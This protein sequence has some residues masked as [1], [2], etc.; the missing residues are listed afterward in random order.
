[1][2]TWTSDELGKIGGTDEL[3]IASRR[4]D[5]TLNSPRIIWVFRLDD[6]LYVR[7]VNARGSAWFRGTQ[8]RHEGHIQAGGVSKNVTFTDPGRRSRRPDRRCL[9]GQVPPTCGEH[10]RPHHQPASAGGDHQTRAGHLGARRRVSVDSLP[11]QPTVKA[12]GGDVHR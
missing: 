8:V 9:P 11:K 10:R 6:D 3:R 5:G 7:S 2:A 12:P 4:R 1:M